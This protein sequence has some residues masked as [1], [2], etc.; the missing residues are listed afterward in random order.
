MDYEGK[1]FTKLY[2]RDNEMPVLK[3]GDVVLCYT[4]EEVVDASRNISDKYTTAQRS[5]LEITI[6]GIK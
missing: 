3:P 4:F 2:L 6:T 1:Y 5:A